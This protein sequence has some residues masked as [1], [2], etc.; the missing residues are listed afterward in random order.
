[1]PS[2]NIDDSR[3]NT[4]FITLKTNKNVNIFTSRKYFDLI[5]KSLDYCQK[6]K[7][8]Q[9]L[10][11]AILS[12]H[13]H[14]VFRI[15]EKIILKD[16]IR[17]FKHFTANQIIKLLKQENKTALLNVFYES[18]KN[19]KDRENKV[20]R[21]TVHTEVIYSDKFREQKIKYVDLNAVHHKIVNDPTKY[22]YT[23]F[24]NHYKNI[25]SECKVVLEI[26]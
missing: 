15:K 2:I 8:M 17:D 11:Y 6:N 9:I 3:Y 23:S 16:L 7:G 20:W 25:Y 26:I 10:A 19:L 14:L 21:R 13:I 18:A 24:H 5:L 22:L 4:F 1:M 12:N